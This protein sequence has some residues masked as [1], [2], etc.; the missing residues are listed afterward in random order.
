MNSRRLMQSCVYRDVSG[1]I[2]DKQDCIST[3]DIAYLRELLLTKAEISMLDH[4]WSS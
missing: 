4:S 2:G 3:M 1:R